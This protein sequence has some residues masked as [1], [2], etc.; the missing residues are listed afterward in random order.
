MKTLITTFIKY[1]VLLLVLFPARF[2]TQTSAEENSVW[3]IAELDLGRNAKGV[4]DL[5]ADVILELN[6]ARANPAKYAELYIKPRI[7]NFKGKIYN[8]NLITREGSSVVQECVRVMSS[9]PKL[10]PLSVDNELTEFAKYH[11]EKQSKTVL[12]GHNK[13]GKSFKKRSKFLVKKG[14]M[15]G[16]N[17]S[18]GDNSGRE[19]V[20]SLLIDDGVSGRGHRKNIFTEG[21]THVGASYG[22]HK[23]FRHMCTIDFYGKP[24]KKK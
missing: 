1:F 3:N 4:S 11:T 23:L 10:S 15:V 9:T 18:Y 6:K 20:I 8:G 21:Y 19:I 5:E 24:V 7:K 16:E 2:L 13:P 17:I 22:D 14:L 12:V